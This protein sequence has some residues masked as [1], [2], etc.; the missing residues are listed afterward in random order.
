MTSIHATH[1]DAFDSTCPTC[2]QRA[3]GRPEILTVF[4]DEQPQSYE[5]TADSTRPILG[6]VLLVLALVV[7]IA[8]G[9]I[10]A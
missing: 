5:L 10:T 1:P 7:G 8:L 2:W 6:A 4:E 3:Q 9:R